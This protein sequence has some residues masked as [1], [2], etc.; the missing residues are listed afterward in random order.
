MEKN[1][2]LWVAIGALFLAVLFMTFKIAGA[3]SLASAAAPAAKAAAG[4]MVG[5]C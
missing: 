1:T 4:A 2:I 3:S 5:G